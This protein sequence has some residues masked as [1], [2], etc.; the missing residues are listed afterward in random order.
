MPSRLVR[1]VAAGLLIAS[2]GGD[3]PDPPEAEPG[4]RLIEGLGPTHMAISTGSEQAQRYFDQGL[5]L[6]FGFNHAVAIRSFREAIRLDPDCAICFWGVALALGP[7]INAPMGPE[8]HREAW[9]AVERARELA[10]GAT[11]RELAYIDALSVRYA[12]DPQ[13]DRAMLDRAYAD[14][15]REVSQ[16]DPEDV[17]AAVLFAEALM[18]LNPWNH[19]TKDGEPIAETPEIVATLEEALERD[20]EH[21]GAAHYL[22]HA[23]EASQDP[24]RAEAAADRLVGLVP[25]SGHLVHMPSHI[26]WRVGRYRDAVEVNREATRTDEDLF[27]FCSSGGLYGAVYY[28][29]NIHFK[30]AAAAAS[31][32]AELALITARRLAAVVDDEMV[33]SFPTAQEFLAVPVETLV[34]FGKW[35]TILGEPAPPPARVYQTG[36]WHYARGIARTRTGEIEQAGAELEKLLEIALGEVAQNLQ[37]YGGSAGQLLEIA[38][39]QLE[40]EMLAG[41]REYDAAVAALER[42]VQKQDALPYMEPPA[43]YFPTRQALG[44]VLL[45]AERSA[46]AEKVYL[47]DLE[48]YPGNGWS[49][50]GLSESLRRQ[51]KD[52]EAVI[53]GEGFQLA[54]TDADVQLPASRF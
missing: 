49:L 47:A 24:G 7:N 18:N 41:Q 6:T 35:D 39:H 44:A 16:G 52:D 9:L 13:T 43:F 26:Y 14:A 25:A 50:Y 46:A 33:A 12:S 23:V 34:R 19:W 36:M 40:G 51:G 29:H 42:A 4:I 3:A 8:A 28:P 5:V 22:I 45:D 15:M 53:V 30:W 38:A 31:G 1:L 37:F 27:A 17:H 10:G 11:P 32:R 48:Q 20:P 54:W 2:C 21:P